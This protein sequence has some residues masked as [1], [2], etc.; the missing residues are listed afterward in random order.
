VRRSLALSLALIIPLAARGDAPADDSPKRIA[1][2][3]PSP[4]RI[5]SDSPWRVDAPIGPTRTLAFDTDEGTW[6][7]LDVHPDGRRIVFS[8]L[9]DLYLLPIEG[10]DAKRITSG[11]AY[12]VQPRFSP[13]G[14][15]I[16]FASDRSGIE[17]L[18]LCDLEGGG[19][20]ALTR[21]K[22]GTVSAPAWSPDGE[23]VVGRK[24]ITD[25]SSLAT[26]ELWIWHAKGGAGVQLTKREEQPDAADPAFAAGS[27]GRFLYFSARDGRY[28]YGRN[29][30]EGI[31]QIKRLDRRDG[32]RIP[33]SGE[34]G[35]AA[36]P[37][38]S[39]DGKNMAFV[40]RVR[41]RTRIELMDLASGRTR[42]LA[43]DVQ[44]DNQ[45]GFAFHGVF[46]GYAFTPDGKALIASANNKIWRFD[47]A[48]GARS[49]IPFRAHVE[50]TITE[51]LRQPRR[52]AEGD[53]RARVLRWASLSPD[54]KTVAFQAFG[55]IWTMPAR[56]GAP[57]RFTD[58]TELEVSPAFSPDGRE[59]VYASWNDREG[60][61]IFRRALRG[62]KPVRITS[63]PGQYANPAFSPD[64][65]KIVFVRG[66][67]AT[68]RDQDPGNELWFEVS[69]ASRSGGATHYV[70][71][72]ENRG[73]D[74]R[75]PRPAFSRD[76]TRV[77]FVDDEA[78]AE[79]A[80]PPRTV[81]YSAT[82]A[83][84]DKRAHLRFTR[85][86][87]VAVSP[88]A[89]HVAFNEQHDAFVTALPNAT[90]GPI[91]VALEEGAL[92]VAR[93]SD[94]GGEWVAWARGGEAISFVRGPE[95]FVTQLADALPTP[96]PEPD[97]P[98]SSADEA[99]DE[100]EKEEPPLPHSERI[101]VELR[102]PRAR[103]SGLVAYTGAR[104]VTMRG[105]EV[106]ERGTLLVDGPRIRA[107]G[108]DV[109]I[110]TNARRVELSGRTLIPGLFDEHAHL[111][112]STAD[113]HPQRPWKYLANLAYGVT[114]THDVSATSHEVFA[115]SERVEAGLMVGPRIFSTGSVL[116]G[117]D[118]P[119]RT[120][121]K[122]LADARKTLRRMK[123]FGAFS[124][125]SYMQPGRNQR[126]WILQAAREEGM[127]VVPEGGGDLEM[128]MTMLL[129]G[130]TTIE[131]ALPIAPLG[132]DVIELF[133]K[134]GTAYTPTLLVAYGGLEGDR[135]FHQH[136]EVWKDERLARYVPQGILDLVGR[137]RLMASDPADWHHLA[138][139]AS[140]KD[141]LRAGAL[142]NLG[143]HGQ[144]QGLGPHW[145]MWAF[146]QGGMTPLEALRVATLNPAKTLG[147]DA[148]LGSLEVGKLADF[149]VLAKNPLE[150]IEHSDSVEL[151]VKNGV[152]YTPEELARAK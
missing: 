21:E 71:S 31:W 60:G 126:Q 67:G 36:A 79:P 52:A 151:V 113:V 150:K 80:T 63:T 105:D 106:I 28:Q 13:D 35:G 87:E 107:V 108:A 134:S 128:D 1:S 33:L 93:L 111:H 133:A 123:A 2:D 84:E 117:A 152:A 130:H 102:I 73:N 18:W 55:Q 141:L 68:F 7:H 147:L 15:S 103:P 65:S 59:L 82:L 53:V 44:R 56:G 20:R 129:D 39:R 98:A 101:A 32:K 14:R 4:K 42:L 118:S 116:Y 17:N 110:P 144:M 139:A 85:A 96:E 109:E 97:P 99:G 142:V 16:A 90:N 78:A 86:E 58:A 122:S 74:R 45:E 66:S 88:D 89:R 114:S 41:A 121:I 81:L 100:E 26:V 138:V 132:R 119:N 24:R 83:G 75:I 149:A 10:G 9:G 131:H 95:L 64:G 48:S 54:A 148:D 69:W 11:P 38:F 37:T 125:K 3:S 76:G 27:D 61:H 135:W 62:G 5:A 30:N 77:Y 29:V 50:Q 115:Q 46:P 94:E 23:W 112:Y 40:R 136:Y 70:A 49:A 145:E 137:I 143:G 127:L 51:A 6:L 124:V 92:P 34:L 22:E 146:V 57:R 91:E 140:A 12:D 72:V 25:Q 47:T 19:A 8:L 120:I 43:D 104:I